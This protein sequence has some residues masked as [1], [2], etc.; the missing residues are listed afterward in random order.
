MSCPESEENS[1]GV[2][3]LNPLGSHLG[4]HHVS[5]TPARSF[6]EIQECLAHPNSR[7]FGTPGYENK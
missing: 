4:D 3:R 5:K 6:E 1:S 2:E 7:V